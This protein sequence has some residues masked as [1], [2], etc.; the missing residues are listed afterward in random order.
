MSRH[1]PNIFFKSLD[2]M[3]RLHKSDAWGGV[4]AGGRQFPNTVYV[5]PQT[6][7]L[8]TVAHSGIKLKQN[9]KTA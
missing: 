1:V 6:S 2:E 8:K 9:T 3:P 4:K 7:R 5:T